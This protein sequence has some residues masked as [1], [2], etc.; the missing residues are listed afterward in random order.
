MQGAL[1]TLNGLAMLMLAGMSDLA[2]STRLSVA[3]V[4]GVNLLLLVDRQALATRPA[5]WGAGASL[6]GYTGTVVF[7]LVMALGC[8][9][10]YVNPRC[11]AVVTPLIAAAVVVSLAGV[12]VGRVGGFFVRR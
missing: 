12:P 2:G 4:V 6:V 11:D 10:E 7:W 3:A 9:I 1:T 8:G 5:R